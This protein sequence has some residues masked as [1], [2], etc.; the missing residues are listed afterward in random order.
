MLLLSKQHSL[1]L[2]FLFVSS[3]DFNTVKV[4]LKKPVKNGKG[5]AL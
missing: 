3:C 5:K 1:T 2:L 4:D